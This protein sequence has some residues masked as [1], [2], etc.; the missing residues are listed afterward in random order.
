MITFN[1]LGKLGRLGNQLF[2]IASTIGIAEKNGI[3]YTLPN[4]SYSHFFKN[5]I[6]LNVINDLE[7]INEINFHYNEIMLQDKTKNY[8]LSGYFQSEKY[9]KESSDLILETFSLKDEI[10]NELKSKYSTILNN[11]CSIHVRRGDYVHLQGYHPVQPL[12]YYIESIKTIYGDNIENINFLI[13]SDDI[14]WCKS[15][16]ILPNTFH[17]EGNPDILDLFLMS[18]CNNNIITNSSFSWWS[19]WLNM[20]PQKIIVAP[21]KWF[22]EYKDCNTKDLIPN[23]WILI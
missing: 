2:Q 15:N 9:F 20:N 1:S 6:P 19:A 4:W 3:K 18:M 22:G 8:D 12:D 5:Q 16:I 14:E 21:K 13:F 10:H 23:N 11:S 17:I 7:V